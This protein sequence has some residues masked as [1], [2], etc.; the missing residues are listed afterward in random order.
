MSP[1]AQPQGYPGRPGYPQGNPQ[2]GYPQQGYPQQGYPQQGYPQQGYPQ[3]GYPQQYYPQ[4]PQ[5]PQ[6]QLPQQPPGADQGDDEP[7]GFGF[8]MALGTDFPLGFGPQLTL[9]IPG[10]L[11]VQG[12]F[13]WMPAAYGSAIV[14]LIE[15]FGK[16]E[17]LLGP[18][19]EDALADSF[20]F[21]ASLGWRPFPSAGFELFAGYTTISVSGTAPPQVIADI[22]EGDLAKE[23]KAELTEDTSVDAQLHNFHVGLGWR[24]LAFEDHLLIRIA[25]GYTQTVDSSSSIS[26]SQNPELETRLA[27][28]FT[29]ALHNILTNDVKLPVFRANVGYRF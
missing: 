20:V 6:Q 4:Q 1:A 16:D 29:D 13:A 17:A 26:V 24:W 11:F 2:Q 22:I 21:R 5:L 12:T 27:P 19:I 10:R 15:A 18:V 14:G 9:E 25:L 3:Q 8:A 7:S 28:T 23:V